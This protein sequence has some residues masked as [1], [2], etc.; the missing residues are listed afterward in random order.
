[1]EH[2]RKLAWGDTVEEF[3]PR[4]RE[5]DDGGDSFA[6]LDRLLRV[7][8]AAEER[9]A[10][11]PRGRN[12]LSEYDL[13]A[14]VDLVGQ[15]GHAMRETHE[16]AQEMEARHQSLMERATEQLNA[17]E[18]RIKAAETRARIAEARLQEMEGRV[19]DA[20]AR[21]KKAEEW[22]LRIHR[23]VVDMLNRGSAQAA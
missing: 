3:R 8:L 1:M 11:L 21:A 23:A 12:G 15:A 18:A 13:A 6:H 5:E 14:A 17:A 4:S 16:R 22:L 19:R 20:E 7:A 2:A 10:E 9:P